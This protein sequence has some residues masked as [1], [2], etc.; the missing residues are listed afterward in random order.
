MA[1]VFDEEKIE[2]LK[3]ISEKV[4]ERAPDWV[5]KKINEQ[6]KDFC[7][8]FV[9]SRGNGSQAVMRA[10]YGTKNAR[11]SAN[12]LLKKDYIQEYKRILVEVLGEDN[13]NIA[14]A[15]EILQFLTATMRGELKEEQ[16]VMVGD[17]DGMSHP[18]I[19]EK[20]VTPKDRI[21]AAKELARIHGMGQTKV[22]VSGSLP[23]IIMGEGDLDD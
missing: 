17:G 21:S 8:F 2:R 15:E 18:D 11:A 3:S 1:E 4:E 12:R 23:V 20:Q 16:V 19:H 5:K 7:V 22:E 6:Q 9:A 14:E 10:G 13:K